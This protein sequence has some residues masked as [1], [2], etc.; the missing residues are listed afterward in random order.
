MKKAILAFSL[1]AFLCEAIAGESIQP[2]GTKELIARPRDYDGKDI[3]FEGEAIGDPMKRG[4]HAW[5]N[6]L[7]SNAAI[8]VFLPE[9]ALAAIENYGSNRRRGDTLR[10]RGVFHRA[11]PD[12]G[13]DMDIHADTVE[14]VERGSP[15][16]HPVDRLELVLL[17]VSF[18]LAALF[19]VLWRKRERTAQSGR[20]LF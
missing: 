10:V 6:L 9:S 3:V 11:C 8:G 7:D 15:T 1:F 13:G 2:V 12:H 17:P 14:I 16:P 18:L 19:Y 5:V 20:R 4:D